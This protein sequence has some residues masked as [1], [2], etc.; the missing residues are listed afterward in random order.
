VMM[1]AGTQ[2]QYVN[3]RGVTASEPDR[4]PSEEGR[5]AL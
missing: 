2:V 3:N 1:P 5:F 4:E